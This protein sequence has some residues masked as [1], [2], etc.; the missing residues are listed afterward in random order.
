M[1]TNTLFLWLLILPFAGAMVTYLIGRVAIAQKARNNPARWLALVVF[2]I[3]DYLFILLAE[4]FLATGPVDLMFGAVAMQ[5]D[6][7]SLV[8]GG[9][10]LLLGTLASLF[11]VDYIAGEIGSEIEKSLKDVS[12]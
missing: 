1:D 12:K 2:L 11:S 8:L 4:R 7:I 9:C 10:A 3:A 5:F 6:G